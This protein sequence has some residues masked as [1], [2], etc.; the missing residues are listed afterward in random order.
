MYTVSCFHCLQ[1]K[2]TKWRFLCVLEVCVFVLCG[3]VK[4]AKYSS[5]FVVVCVCLFAV[6]SAVLISRGEVLCVLC[7]VQALKELLRWWWK[8]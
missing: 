2:E 7:R 4:S 5:I 1:K 8:K 6:S 3:K